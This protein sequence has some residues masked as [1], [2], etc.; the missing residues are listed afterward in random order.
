MN[1][2]NV[3]DILEER[4]FIYQCT[5][6][7]ALRELLGRE[8]ISCYI[9]YDPTAAT[10]HVGSLVPVMAMVHMQ[11]AGHRNIAIVGGGTAMVGDP[12]G[13]TEMRKML[14][15]EQIEKNAEGLKE[16]LGRFLDFA[17]G[18]ALMINN[19]DWLLS[20]NYVEF[21]REI[22]RHF[23]V[24]RMLTAESY[25]NRLETGLSFLEFNYMLLQAYDF[26]VLKRDHGC[27]LQMGGQDQWGNIVAGSDLIRRQL[28]E[29]AFGLTFPLLM[30][31]NGEKFGKTAAGAVWLDEQRTPPFD[32][33]QFW[34]NCDDGEVKR[35]LGLFT[36]L[37]MEEA[38]RLSALAPPALN[39]AKE[40]LAFEVTRMTHGHE[41]AVQAYTSAVRQFG[42]AD[43]EGLISTSSCIREISLNV[44]DIIPSTG[45][46]SAR[47]ET[48][49]DLAGLLLEAN[50]AASRAEVKRLASQ[51]GLTVNERRI[52]SMPCV[53]RLADLQDGALLVRLGKKRLHRF[54]A[55]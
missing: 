54:I 7:A 12:S 41:K 40:I 2:P 23:S 39:R 38:G 49:A 3:Y 34:R 11:R 47:F 16:Q 36:F 33:Y 26:Y 5:D 52:D 14:T 32:F 30:N 4:G 9:G 28:N 55:E 44:Q 22:G 18:R 24:N 50:L 45:V 48:G 53:I 1:Q 15:L 10:L 20:L 42:A 25:R 35:L 6:P 51:G 43:P 31:A 17:G 27:V 37:P 8:S 21:L 19:A 29:P 13:K 46:P